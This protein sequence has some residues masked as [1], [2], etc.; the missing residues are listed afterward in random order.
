MKKKL[1]NIFLKGGVLIKS[2]FEY[3]LL[4]S[5]I[6]F[7][8][9]RFN[10]EKNKSRASTSISSLIDTINNVLKYNNDK[11]VLDF[12]SANVDDVLEGTSIIL[13]WE[14]SGIE[15][16]FLNGEAIP[17][18]Q[19]KIKITPPKSIKYELSAENP[20][21]RTILTKNIIV[22]YLPEIDYI[23]VDEEM[24]FYIA[25]DLVEITWK[26]KNEQDV[27]LICTSNINSI[28]KINVLHKKKYFKTFSHDVEIYIMARNKY[29]VKA[30]KKIR[31]RIARLPKYDV[32]IPFPNIMLT[33]VVPKAVP[34]FDFFIEKSE[35]IMPFPEEI[36]NLSK[37]TI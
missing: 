5:N 22:G 23:K 37:I 33:Q 8:G 12:F 6:Y 19:K 26:T 27:W 15:K 3:L 20:F 16:L 35:L 25:G 28:E 21:G 1:Y 17:K 31:I 36:L 13:S 7:G 32:K 4:K 29:G 11:P 9:D 24:P 10:I 18:E 2:V 34:K 14:G 30:S